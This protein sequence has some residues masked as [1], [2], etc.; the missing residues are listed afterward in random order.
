MT[1]L[2]PFIWFSFII[3]MACGCGASDSGGD[4]DRTPAQTV[5]SGTLDLSTVV[6]SRDLVVV[7]TGLDPLVGS[8]W[9]QEEFVKDLILA[10][11]E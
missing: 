4:K 9:S 10:I 2:R 11:D 1:L 5:I 7:R 6:P 3:L 8:R